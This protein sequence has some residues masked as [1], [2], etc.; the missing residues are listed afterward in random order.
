MF[1]APTTTWRERKLLL[2]AVINEVVVTVAEPAR[3]AEVNIVWEG[4]ATTSFG[5]D[6]NKTGKH[7]RT[8]DEDT[9]DLVRRLAQRYDDKTIAA[10]LSK[11]R[12]R[13]G[14]GLAF[15]RT[16]VK[17]LR[18]SRGIPAY[19][20][21]EVVTPTGDDDLVVSITRAEKLLGVS[22]SRCIAGSTTGSST[23]SNSPPAA[24]GTSAS[25]TTSAA[26]SWATSPTAGSNLDQSSQG[27]RRRPP[28][29]VTQGP[30]RRPRSRPRQ[31]RAP[32]RLTYQGKRH[33]RLDCS[34]QPDERKRSVNQ[35]RPARIY[36]PIRRRG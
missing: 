5:L 31:P 9:V 14:T 25:P 13:T 6:L 20:P 10:I 18:V 3:H 16:R 33:Q 8:T 36:R 12:R 32:K 28:D 27:P 11:Q 19:K 34:T 30:A 21:P 22:R 17:T 24:H 1:D 26:A 23:A 35:D 29:G 15:T 7:F 2:R 4:G